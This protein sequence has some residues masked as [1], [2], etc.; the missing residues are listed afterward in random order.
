MIQKLLFVFCFVLL[1][2]AVSVAQSRSVSNLD[3]EKYRQQR[4]T[5]E[6]ELRE[7]YAKLGFSS[8][9][10]MQRRDEKSRAETEAL[11]AK[12]RAERLERE[13]VDAQREDAARL[14]AYYRY[15]ESDAPGVDASAVFFWQN[16]QRYRRP[17]RRIQ[18]RNGYFAGGQFW[19]TGPRTRPQPLWVR[20][21]R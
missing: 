20:P 21:R 19:A 15:R 14:A 2:V 18:F 7:N 3:L 13:R 17:A 9:E 6:A 5:A 10:E 4:I 12:L 1:T 8:P 11:A 16:G